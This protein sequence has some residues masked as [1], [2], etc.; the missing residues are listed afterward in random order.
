MMTSL[1]FSAYNKPGFEKHAYGL[2]IEPLHTKILVMDFD[3]PDPK[4]IAFTK[5][6]LLKREDINIIDIVT[7]SFDV[8][9]HPKGRHLYAGLA[10]PQNL[11]SFY[12][13]G[14]Q[15]SCN[16]FNKLIVRKGE[17]VIRVSQKFENG[18]PIPGSEMRWEEGYTRI[19]ADKWLKFTSEQLIAP[20]ISADVHFFG[21]TNRGLNHT[22]RLRG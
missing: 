14:I 20:L 11:I 21:E 3:D 9:G 8:T 17:I 5:K 16:G 15:G 12:N 2:L 13:L 4:P 6:L 7:S 1:S 22:L 19:G 18:K 10:T